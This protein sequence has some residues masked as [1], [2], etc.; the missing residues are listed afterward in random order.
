MRPQHNTAED[1]FY[2]YQQRFF[3]QR[4]NEAAA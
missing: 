4:F 3:M 2:S 1:Q